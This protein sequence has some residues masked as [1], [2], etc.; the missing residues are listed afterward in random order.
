MAIHK[1]D[2]GA[3]RV[4]HCRRLRLRSTN[5]TLHRR[6][7]IGKLDPVHTADLLQHLPRV[8]RG[9]ILKDDRART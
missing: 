1:A 5:G 2:P 3:A 6:Q 4:S 8:A 9:T 7:A